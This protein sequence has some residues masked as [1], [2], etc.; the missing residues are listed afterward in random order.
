MDKDTLY[1]HFSNLALV[2]IALFSI[3]A[4]FNYF[5][6]ITLLLGTVGGF[7]V[8]WMLKDSK[9][10]HMD[11]FVGMLSLA[12]IVIVLGALYDTAMTLENLLRIFSTALVWLLLFQSFNLRTESSYTMVQF[13]SVILLI[14]SVSIPLEGESF[15]IVLLSLFLFIF[16]F[17]MRLNLVCERSRKGSLIIGEKREAM[18]LYQQIKVCALM[19]SFVLIVASFV[20]PFV[21]RFENLS[22]RWIPSALL[23]I[24]EQVPMLKEDNESPA[25]VEDNKE[26][27]DEQLFDD[28]TEQ[29]ETDE[30]HPR[31]GEIEE[32]QKVERFPARDFD[33]SIDVFKI[34][35]LNIRANIEKLPLDGQAKLEAELNLS[36]GSVIP[37]TRLV[38]WKVVGNAEVSL[39]ADG[40]LIPKGQGDI[41]V[42]ASYMGTFSNDIEIKI[43]EPVKPIEKRSWIYY[44][45]VV[46]LDL[47]ILS[48]AGFSVWI[49]MK[50][51]RLRELAIREP[52]EFI[53]KL[54]NSL[55]RGFRPYGAYNLDYM[56]PREFFNSVRNIVASKPEPMHYMTE[57]L[58]EARF[59]THEISAEHS[60]KILELFHEVKDI[61]LQK[62]EPRCFWKKILFRLFTLDTLLIPRDII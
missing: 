21:P 24:L 3:N 56:A 23:G 6:F 43:V 4:I 29:R 20:Y 62:E 48:I 50:T 34:E 30:G 8:S 36:D 14:S 15:Y 2:I 19:F 16:I 39:D 49:F 44:F 40:N 17:T 26:L 41:C 55:R 10:H 52:R 5:L 7:V 57:G 27:K 31:E 58:L 46:L 28:G 9:L 51:K 47:F 38:D 18:S 42:S 37:A 61:V 1:Y 33:S 54:Y 11:T 60:Q 13:I 22:L 59:S 32:V 53:R 45:F 25:T 12:A 35:S